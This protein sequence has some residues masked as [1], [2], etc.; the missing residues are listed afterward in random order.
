MNNL[1]KEIQEGIFVR[2]WELEQKLNFPV[3]NKLKAKALKH[4]IND[5]ESIIKN[6]IKISK[7][8]D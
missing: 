5:A 4:Q 2:E 6:N 3:F 1:L 8:M 7:V